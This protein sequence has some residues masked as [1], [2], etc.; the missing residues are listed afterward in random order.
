MHSELV[1]N[2]DTCVIEAIIDSDLLNLTEFRNRR[3]LKLGM[4]M[5]E[6]NFRS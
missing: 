4:F 3:E 6:L 2:H 1:T 5:T